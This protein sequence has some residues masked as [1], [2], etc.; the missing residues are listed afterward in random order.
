MEH[1]ETRK[2][3]SHSADKV[4]QLTGD[5]GALHQWV[6]GASQCVVSGEG[7]KDQGGNAERKVTLMDGSVTR[8]SLETL[9]NTERHY[10]YAILEAKGFSKD[11]QFFGDFQVQPINDN[12]CE[13]IWQASFSV[14]EGLTEEKVSGMKQRL[15]QMYGFFLQNLETV[16]ADQ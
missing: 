16:L 7:A 3:F 12:Q 5:F 13:V 8:E 15:Q 2:T 1:I 4:W 10:R 9:N 14:P 11:T 6:P